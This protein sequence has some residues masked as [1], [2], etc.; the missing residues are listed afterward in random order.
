MQKKTLQVLTATLLLS[1]I[2]CARANAQTPDTQPPPE[3]N[4]PWSVS[5]GRLR[6]TRGRTHNTLGVAYHLKR[7][8]RSSPALEPYVDVFLGSQNSELYDDGFSTTS[9][10]FE[11]SGLGVGI[12]L[13]K[14]GKSNPNGNV[15]G[16]YYGVGAGVYYT[17][18]SVG[19]TVELERFPQPSFVFSQS[20][21]RRLL[22]LGGKLFVGLTL[23]RSLFAEVS[24]QLPTAPIYTVSQNGER[25]NVGGDFSDDL[26][27]IGY[28]FGFRF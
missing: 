14:S 8:R 26:G 16:L 4:R 22:S 12:S 18:S 13:V 23:T 19:V 28:R 20:R 10:R 6:T 24:L 9:R 15:S 5:L 11:V 27:G 1:A 7:A 17:S 2:G 21:S 3:Y 25:G